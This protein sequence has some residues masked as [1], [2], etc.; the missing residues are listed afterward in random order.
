MY[1]EIIFYM[2]NDSCRKKSD[3][4]TR[5]S[6]FFSPQTK[7]CRGRA[8]QALRR[9]GQFGQTI[10]LHSLVSKFQDLL[11]VG[12]LTLTGNSPSATTMS[13]AMSIMSSATSAMFLA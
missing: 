1:F 8:P 2:Y 12:V 5:E 10:V 13:R 6:G 7:G 9:M 3:Q 4:G 11:A